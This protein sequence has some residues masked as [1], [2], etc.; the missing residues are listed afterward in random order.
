[1]SY[2]TN[3]KALRLGISH[4]WSF[5]AHG[6]MPNLHLDH[7][8]MQFVTNMV[9]HVVPQAPQRA[10]TKGRFLKKFAASPGIQGKTFVLRGSNHVQLVIYFY[11]NLNGAEEH[12]R[13][14]L[15]RNFTNIV[16]LLRSET[17]YRVQIAVLNYF[18]FF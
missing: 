18:S 3:A 9:E 6:P 8:L 15:F 5:K 7:K 2:K 11:L 16:W 14:D 4:D 17:G 1:M 12:Q 10:K 13:Q